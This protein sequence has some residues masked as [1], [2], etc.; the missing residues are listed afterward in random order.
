MGPIWSGAGGAGTR[1][2]DVPRLTGAIL[3][4]GIAD[5]VTSHVGAEA[6]AGWPS[7]PTAIVA[8]D[9]RSGRRVAFG[10]DMAPDVGLDDAVAASS[11][12][13]LVFRPYPIGDGLYV[14]GG[15]SSGT[16][17]DLVL[18]HGRPLDLVLVIAP[19]AAEVHRHRAMF[20]EKMF[21][22]VGVKALSRE[23][24]RDQDRHGPTVT[25]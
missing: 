9:I 3:G 11:A 14:D 21:D 4:V 10:T 13:P 5:W 16:H 15:V 6:A 2:H 12:V 1:T 22:R 25:S 8:Y 17:A 24:A 7:Q 19:M 23:A 18:G 20:H